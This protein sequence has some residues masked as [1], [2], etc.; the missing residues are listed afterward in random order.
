MA[1]SEE[2]WIKDL[3]PVLTEQCKLIGIDHIPTTYKVVETMLATLPDGTSLFLRPG[4][5]IRQREVVDRPNVGARG[6]LLEA[7]RHIA[8]I[9]P[10]E[11]N[12]ACKHERR[13]QE[14]ARQ[15]M[16]L[17]DRALEVLNCAAKTEG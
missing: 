17:L 12:P 14:I 7:R 10:S 11:K 9:A 1:N 6:P 15:V 2:G 3:G 13:A 16:V 5:L 8:E 4:T